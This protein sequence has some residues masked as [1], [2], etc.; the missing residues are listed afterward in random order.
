M[1]RA[2][3]AWLTQRPWH[4]AIAIAFCGAL[5]QLMLPFS[6]LACAIP[7]LCVL[8]FDARIGAMVA[9]I[10]AASA[11]W[12]VHSAAASA[13]AAT[14]AGIAV[15]F[16][17]PLGLALLLK[18]TG[19]LNLCFQVAVLGIGVLLTIV[20]A[21]LADPVG[22]WTSLLNQL[23]DSMEAAGIS[24]Q[25]DRQELVATWARS[26]WGAL[27]ALTLASV[28]GALLLGRWWQSLLNAPGAFGVEYRGLRLGVTL[29]V[30][31]TALFVLALTIDSPL[32]AS[33]AWVAFVALTFQGLA[34][35]HRSRAGGR[36]NR[37]WLAAIY[38]LLVVPLS[39]MVTMFVLA[40]WG[41]ADNWL[42]PRRPAS[43]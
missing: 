24:I 38:L 1:H 39:M 13:L 20:H 28:F 8:R 27:G 2:I 23:L 32:I 37:G 6:V 31:V 35:A 19:S 34:A 29:G 12:I 42:R 26:M 4:A 10:G 11:A 3:A 5:S 7:V 21:V 36:L 14:L 9:A 22:V 25:Q 18:R 15:M 33:L 30:V 41:F 16:F 43:L 17:G 40:I